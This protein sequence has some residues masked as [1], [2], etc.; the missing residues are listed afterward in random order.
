MMRRILP[1]R[2][3]SKFG[4]FFSVVPDAGLECL[5]LGGVGCF[6][7]V[8]LVQSSESHS[9]AWNGRKALRIS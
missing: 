3:S 4:A 7:F 6:Q 9:G 5:V 8:K 1:W 2:M